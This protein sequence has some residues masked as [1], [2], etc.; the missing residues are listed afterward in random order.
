MRENAIPHGS[1][2]VIL[3]SSRN[4]PRKMFEQVATQLRADGKQVTTLS[5]EQFHSYQLGNHG[6]TTAIY[7]TRRLARDCPAILERMNAGEFKR[8]RA[9]AVKQGSSLFVSDPVLPSG[10]ETDST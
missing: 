10:Q 3:P 9:A 8:V 7:L 4:R 6:S 1:T 5:A 2:L